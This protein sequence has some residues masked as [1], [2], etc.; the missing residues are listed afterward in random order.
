MVIIEI[1]VSAIVNPP[2]AP[3]IPGPEPAPA[4][5]PHASRWKWLAAA[6]LIVSLVIVGYLARPRPAKK[7]APAVA[8]RTVRVSG[9]P[10]VTTLRIAGTT[11]A[12]NFANVAA[13]MMRGPDSGRD[14]I[15]MK[16]VKAGAYVKKG[17]IIAEIDAQSIKDH[18]NDINT[19]VIQADADV[20]KRKAEQAIEMET[21]R[22]TVRL[23]KA[24][25]EKAKLDVGAAEI[26]SVIDQ[27]QLKLAVEEAEAT[28]KQVQQDLATTAALHHAEL[29]ILELTRDR[30][31]HHRDRHAADVKLFTM[32]A[33]VSGLAVMETIWRGGDMG[34]VQEGDDV[35]P[36]EPF[37]KIV[38]T[39]EMTL[40]G[41]INQVEAELIHIGQVAEV[42]L[43]AFPGLRLKGTVRSVGAL[44]QG[45]WRQNDYIRSI[46]VTIALETTDQRVIPDLSAFAEVVL[47]R[48]DDA[49]QLPAEAVQ[50][51][52]GQAAV[53]VK[54]GEQFSRRAVRIGLHNNTRVEVIAG[55][56]LGEEVALQQPAAPL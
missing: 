22:Q 33:P 10:F 34:Q 37:M 5:P 35:D 47:S 49:L 36:G 16:L 44:A 23:A 20:R 18:V 56:V 6:L 21:L 1:K 11:A 14:L 50:T 31:A 25:V 48:K 8:I 32:H 51:A 39:S 9:G 40:E 38:D 2:A 43:D 4:V 29:R 12:H 17:E 15:L 7:P 54:T 55:L 13:P 3:E 28:Y 27:E 30:H 42:G 46:P 19:L 52:G 45:S 24:Q 41:S 26:R 53:Y